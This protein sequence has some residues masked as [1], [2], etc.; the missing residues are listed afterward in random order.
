MKK[1]MLL[2][3]LMPLVLFTA[4]SSDTEEK[5][6]AIDKKEL[7]L[8]HE[9]THSL[10]VARNTKTP[11]FKSE[12]SMIASV[13]KDGLITG[14][15]VGETNIL[16]DTGNGVLKCKV[17]VLPQINFIPS[18]YL[19]FGDTY[20]HVK[21]I[22]T[23]E[24]SDIIKT[25]EGDDYIGIAKNIDNAQFVYGYIFKDRK[26]VMSM[27]LLNVIKY[28]KSV[29]SLVKYITERYYIISQTNSTTYSFVSPQKDIAVVVTNVNDDMTV[30]FAPFKS[31]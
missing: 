29:D 27:I 10:K 9:G 26:L 4:C 25:V 5:S 1:I 18:P 16:V 28:N 2:L 17:E 3:A 8:F 20:E 6:A 23:K 11:T 14:H 31:K 15:C 13:D 12:N 30:S 21:S 19:G 7:K 22:V 24:T